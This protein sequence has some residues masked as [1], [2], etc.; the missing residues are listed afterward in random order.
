M[1]YNY[2]YKEFIWVHTYKGS[3][4]RTLGKQTRHKQSVG[5]NPNIICHMKF[6]F[7]ASRKI[8]NFIIKLQII[9]NKMK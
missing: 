8:V 7:K 1:L 6:H 2:C 9:L 3:Q 4:E 5:K